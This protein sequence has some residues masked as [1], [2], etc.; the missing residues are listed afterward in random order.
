MSDTKKLPKNPMQ[1][2]VLTESGVV[3]FKENAIV[4]ALLDAASE[5]RKMDLNDIAV[6]EFSQ[7]DR[8]QFAQLHGYSLGGFHELSDVPDEVA[9]KASKVARETLGIPDCGG[10]RDNG[11]DI[12]CGVEVED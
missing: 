9:L 12:H 6:M 3:R 4:S 1:P 8:V 5:G 11:C 7:D 10:C 2:F